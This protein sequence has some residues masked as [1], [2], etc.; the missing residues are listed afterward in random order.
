MHHC[1]LCFRSKTNIKKG[2]FNHLTANSYLTFNKKKTL[3]YP[4]LSYLPENQK[5]VGWL[6]GCFWIKTSALVLLEFEIGDGPGP[7]A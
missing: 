1:Y 5:V 4:I 6:G 2:N 7:R 3:Y